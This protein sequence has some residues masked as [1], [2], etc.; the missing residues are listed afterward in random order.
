VK[1]QMT[2]LMI[3]IVLGVLVLGATAALTV[4]PGPN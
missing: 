4:L 3:N 1:R 2:L